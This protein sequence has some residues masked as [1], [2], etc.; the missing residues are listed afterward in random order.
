MITNEEKA[1]EPVWLTSTEL[2]WL[3]SCDKDV[4]KITI[5]D[6]GQI[7]KSYTAGIISA[8]VSDV[9]LK[10]I[11]AS[12]VAIVVVGKA[13]PDGSLYNPAEEAKKYTSGRLYDGLMVRHWDTYVTPEKNSIWHGYLQMEKPHFTES[14]GRWS[15]GNLTNVLRGTKLES[16]I[17]TFGDKGDYD[18]GSN[19]IVFVAKDPALNPATNTKSNLYIVTVIDTIYSEPTVVDVEGLEGAS[20]APALSPDGNGVAF[21]Q[22]KQNGYESDKNRIVLC[23]DISKPFSTIELLKSDDGRGTWDRSP[24]S[25]TWSADGKSLLLIAEEKGRSLLFK[26][27]LPYGI[28]QAELPQPLTDTGSVSD[29]RR[30]GER[31]SS[32]LLSSSNLVDNSVYSIVDAANPGNARI[33][34]SNA[35][36][37]TSF[38][39]SK[40]QVSE[41]WFDGAQE[42]VHAWVLYVYFS[43]STFCILQV[44]NAWCDRRNWLCFR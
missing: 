6:V 22:M 40:N 16:P 10:I 41:I 9:K 37:G 34:S 4:T 18:L 28:G 29:A 32:L 17:P 3:S 30:L 15:L 31:T 26:L 39:L 42:K 24:S 7:G 19:A 11:N 27:M 14:R 38:A 8:P 21:L 44:N 25:I 20:S 35:H 12:K 13:R 1:S 43:V 5:G 33:L 36:N 2:L 23:A